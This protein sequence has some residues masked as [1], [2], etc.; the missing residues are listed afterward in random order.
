[1]QPKRVSIFQA[2]FREM[3][4]PLSFVVEEASFKRSVRAYAT[5][6]LS[7]FV[8]FLPRCV[9]MRLYFSDQVGNPSRAQDDA[10][11]V[12]NTPSHHV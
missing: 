8:L 1:M 6:S 3:T 7:A 5:R 11:P 4:F 10:K 9:S 12:T 2:L